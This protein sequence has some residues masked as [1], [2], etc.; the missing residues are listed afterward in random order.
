[1]N[2]LQRLLGTGVMITVMMSPAAMAQHPGHYGSG[3]LVH[4]VSG[5]SF[6]GGIGR[7]GIGVGAGVGGWGFGAWGFGGWL[8][9]Y[10]MGVPS[11]IFTFVPPMLPMGSEGFVPV[12]APQPLA[13]D[14]GPIAPPPPAGLVDPAHGNRPANKAGQKPKAK[15]SARAGQLVLMG[16]RLFRGNNI[17]KAEER[18]GQA[19]RLDP[20]SAAPLIGLAQVA[21]VR[22]QYGEAAR[23]LREAETA[24]PGWI[25]TAPDVQSIYGEPG[26]FARHLARLESHLQVHPDD[27]DAWLVLG[28]EWYLS[29]RTARGRRLPSAQRS[30][31]Q[32]GY[33]P[34][35]LSPR[36]Q[37]GVTATPQPRPATGEFDQIKR[38]SGGR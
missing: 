26:D 11:G 27:R 37:S 25:V 35:G 30:Q 32:A 23:R 10:P 7:G 31:P 15:D 12:M 6:G 22:V 21:L 18:Y 8:P 19:T 2:L 5:R 24:Q 17:K 29:G 33:R 16:D 13:V 1:M 9:N 20:N 28:A 3:T 14:R 4:H 34:F 38:Q 36:H